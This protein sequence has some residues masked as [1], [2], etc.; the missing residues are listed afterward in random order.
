MRGSRGFGTLRW[1]L[2]AAFLAVAVVAVG[3]LAVSAAVS[4]DR[5]STTIAEQQRDRLREEIAEVLAAAYVAGSG[6]WQADDLAVAA[7]L[8]DTVDTTVVVADG[9]GREVARLGGGDHGAQHTTPPVAPRETHARTRLP[10]SE[11]HG[12]HDE[13]AGS[14]ATRETAWGVAAPVPATDAPVGTAS[15]TI[16]I[17]VD[18]R[19][20]GTALLTLPADEPVAVAAARTAL[21][22]QVGLGAVAAVLVAAVAAFFVSRRLSRPLLALA[23][24]TRAFAD[25]DQNAGA[26]LSPAPGELGAVAEAFTEMATTVRRQDELRRAVVADVAHELRTPVTILRGQTEQLLD[27]VAAPTEGHLVSLHDEVL[28]LERLTDDLVTLSSADAVGLALRLEPVD[29]AALTRQAVEAIRTRFTDAELSVDV[30]ADEVVEVAGDGTRLTQIITNLLTNAAKFTPPGGRV[31]ATTARSGTDAVL[32]VT[33]TGPGIA[34]DELPHVFDRFW[35]G[36]A[37]RGRGGTGIGLAVVAAL[38]R[39]HHGTVTA[40]SA[41]GGGACFTVRLPG[42]ERHKG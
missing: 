18:G 42:P 15:E 7:A 25:G 3:L 10:A 33:D 38:V 6:D 17:V 2:L 31:T 27:G 41:A 9:H 12:D 40:G 19:R 39:A 22:G 36:R 34:E 26:R 20:V 16:P 23:D 29:L 21:L 14:G 5:H 37:A 32:T 4:V 35:R 8:A 1:R 13:P 24:A 28:R 30:R 11:P